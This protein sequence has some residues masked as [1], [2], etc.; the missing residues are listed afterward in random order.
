MN[1]LRRPTTILIKSA[2]LFLDPRRGNSTS[3][4]K[5]SLQ[6]S[7]ASRKKFTIPPRNCAIHSATRSPRA[8]ARLIRDCSGCR[9]SWR[10]R[11]RTSGTT[12]DRR[13]S[14]SRQL[15]EA[16][17]QALNDALAALQ[18]ELTE[19]RTKLQSELRL[20]QEHTAAELDSQVKALRDDKVSRDAIADLFQTAAMRLRGVEMIED[21]RK[22]A[23]TKTGE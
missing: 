22:A 19:A 23:K 4:W 14:N 18:R 9:Q 12:W 6:T 16:R 10:K 8:T 15:W 2:T 21:L 7:I 1:G 17:A 3:V 11:P 13:K 20:L 5:S